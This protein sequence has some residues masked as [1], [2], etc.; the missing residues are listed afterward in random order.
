MRPTPW[1]KGIGGWQKDPETGVYANRLG[2]IRLF[3]LGDRMAY[4]VKAGW[5]HF[6]ST[7]LGPIRMPSPHSTTEW[8]QKARYAF[9]GTFLWD[10]AGRGAVEARDEIVRTLEGEKA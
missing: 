10:D 1:R 8:L 5:R 3:C 9:L 4:R 7:P 2:D 6:K